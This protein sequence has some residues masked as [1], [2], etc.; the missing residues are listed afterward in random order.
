MELEM[1][2]PVP[3]PGLNSLRVTYTDSLEKLLESSLPTAEETEAA[4]QPSIDEIIAEARR[5]KKGPNS[6]PSQTPEDRLRVRKLR[7]LLGQVKG[8]E[9]ELKSATSAAQESSEARMAS[10]AR[11]AESATEYEEAA[12]ELEE[13]R[14][15]GVQMY[16]RSVAARNVELS[17][18][19]HEARL[20][21][22][23]ERSF[24]AENFSWYAITQ[25]L[26]SMLRLDS[27]SEHCLWRSQ[28]HAAI[29]QLEAT[30][31]APK[32]AGG[33]G[34][35]KHPIASGGR[36]GGPLVVPDTDIPL[37]LRNFCR[38]IDGYTAKQT[39]PRLHALAEMLMEREA[40]LNPTFATIR[41]A[42]VAAEKRL[43]EVEAKW[44]SSLGGETPAARAHRAFDGRR[45]EVT[46]KLK[47]AGAHLPPSQDAAAL[48][49]LTVVSGNSGRNISRRGVEVES[50][51]DRMLSELSGVVAGRGSDEARLAMDYHRALI[52]CAAEGD[53]R[54]ALRVYRTLSDRR[55]PCTY[56]TTFQSLLSAA[57][58]AKPH[59]ASSLVVPIMEE[60]EACGFAPTREL[61]HSAMDVCRVAGHW[62]QALALFNRMTAG[63]L[64]P[65]T[66]TYAL[67]EQAGTLA[68]ATEPTEVYSA[69]TYS[70]VPAYL[71][72]TAAAA[73]VLNRLSSDTGP[74]ADLVGASIVPRANAR[75][76]QRRWALLAEGKS[77]VPT[78]SRARGVA[79]SS[80]GEKTAQAAKKAFSAQTAHSNL[81]NTAPAVRTIRQ[82][83]SNVRRA[84][85][86]GAG[87][88]VESK[89]LK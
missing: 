21:K 65:T 38:D 5:T 16:L 87:L 3:S 51:V 28:L 66:Q 73:R 33:M 25:A 86:N 59:A 30:A 26:H 45:L 35:P 88:P 2:P 40:R 78:K 55:L 23:H 50:P 42:R 52:Y 24:A 7:A 82:S 85:G 76:A 58:N 83:P 48:G 81:T 64:N 44:V 34:L 60:V 54:G 8:A 77:T 32:E 10:H 15:A 31:C 49:E 39:V 68:K 89:K 19:R 13:L 37:Y 43:Q 14:E 41:E 67:L 57:K 75:G 61:Y 29:T 84:R 22:E 63:G 47:R 12:T 17:Q 4:A 56:P 11:L 71:S 27:F 53:W 70:G 1:S 18:V 74:V 62:R 9:A 79:P 72:Y 6:I 36:D 46:E 20:R 80:G 69:M